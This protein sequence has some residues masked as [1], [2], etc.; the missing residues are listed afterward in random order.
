[1][2]TTLNT[3]LISINTRILPD[4][5][6]K[7]LIRIAQQDDSPKANQAIEE[8]LNTNVRLI[9]NCIQKIYTTEDIDDLFQVGCIGLINFCPWCGKIIEWSKSS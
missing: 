5:E 6:I 1:M 4:E 7:K 2:K 8:I 9:L 3:S